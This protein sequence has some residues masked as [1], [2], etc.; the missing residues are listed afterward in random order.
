VPKGATVVIALETAN[1]SLA[2]QGVAL[3]SGGRDDVIQIMNPVSRAVVAAKVTAPGRAVILP[4][5]TPLV[6]PA[7]ATPRPSEVAN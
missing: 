6:A 5:S 7:R 2:A 3:D 4:G 1:M